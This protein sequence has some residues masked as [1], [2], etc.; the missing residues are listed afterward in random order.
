MNATLLKFGY[1]TTEI[2]G[3]HHWVILLRRPQITLGSLV[4]AARGE[5]TQLSAIPLAAF[6]ELAAVIKAVEKTLKKLWNYDQLNYLMLMMVDPHV[7]WH[8]I[9]R[10]QKTLQ[11]FNQSFVDQ[12]W[13]KPPDL[14]LSTALI[15]EMEKELI[16]KF[17]K[18]WC[19]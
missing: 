15:P 2:I 13:P 11:W 8:V 18:Y 17:Q 3:Y 1:P 5:E 14:S 12:S 9:P 19:S 4:I 7:H 10:Y 16:L 6:S